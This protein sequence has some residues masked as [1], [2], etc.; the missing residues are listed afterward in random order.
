MVTLLF[1]PSIS[2]KFFSSLGDEYAVIWHPDF[3]PQTVNDAP[4]EYDSP[5]SMLRPIDRPVNRSDIQETVLNISEQ[6][7]VGKLCSLHLANTDLYGVDHLRTL[8]I[9]AHISKELDAPKTGHHSI[10]PEQIMKLQ[11]QLGDARPD[12]F[13]KPYY[14]PYPSRHILGRILLLFFLFIDFISRTI[15]SFITSFRT[16]LDDGSNSPEDHHCMS[17]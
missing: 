13:D 3:V 15:I 4:Y 8:A 6:C 1:F 16:E 17:H 2:K 5:T 14:K 10:T 7:C 9:A 11:E 12:Y